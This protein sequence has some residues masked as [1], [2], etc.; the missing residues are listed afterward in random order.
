MKEQLSE[1][2]VESRL[3]SPRRKE[4]SPTA[5]LPKTSQS[6]QK[7]RKHMVSP[8]LLASPQHKAPTSPSSTSI[9]TTVKIQVS[10]KRQKQIKIS[11]DPG[12]NN[13]VLL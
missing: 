5:N 6:K 1:R 11:L 3:V 8:R 13:D 7:L 2:S 4:A 10:E 12:D 9:N